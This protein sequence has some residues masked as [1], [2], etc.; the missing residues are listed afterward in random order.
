[1]GRI[2]NLLRN[3]NYL[4]KHSLWEQ[5]ESDIVFL[6]NKI[7]DDGIY[8]YNLNIEKRSGIKILSVDETIELLEKKPKSFVRLGDGEL[9]LIKGEGQPFQ[10]YNEEV[11][12]RL[13]QLLS[14]PN[15]N[16]YVGINRAYYMGFK[17]DYHRRW[18]YTFRKDNEIFCNENITYVDA[19]VTN[20]KLSSQ[21]NDE[22]EA[23]F[24][25]W[26]TLFKEKKILV[27][28][29]NKILDKLEYDVFEYAKEKVFLY[30]PKT[31]AWDEHERIINTIL[32]EY[33]KEYLILF[34]LGMGGKAMIPELTE[35]G[36]MCW[37]I[38]HLAKYYDA[39]RKGAVWTSSFARNF[40]S[41][42]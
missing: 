35:K 20:G 32:T 33:D 3:I 19:G 30:G 27:V 41:P 24:E 1:M 10:R 34:I 40:Y 15:E 21:D 13:K 5:R 26:K 25:R 42:D 28:C 39:Y 14:V 38:G 8:E 37:D 2:K 9:N 18:A 4:S 29:G 23:A 31:N 16:I 6:T 7:L 11:A 17:D 22:R 36:Y 12:T